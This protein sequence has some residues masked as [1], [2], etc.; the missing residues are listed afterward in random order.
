MLRVRKERCIGGELHR[1]LIA[2]ESAHE[3]RFADRRAERTVARRI[4]DDGIFADE[5]A[6]IALRRVVF[7]REVPHH[8]VGRRVEMIVA[9]IGL[10][11]VDDRFRLLP[12][13][14]DER[15]V[16]ILRR[17]GIRHQLV[18]L[19]VLLAAVLVADF[20]ILEVKGFRMS[21]RGALRAPDG[22]R[23]AVAV[24]ET[25]ERILNELVHLVHRDRLP[26]G[27]ADVDA[28]ERLRLQHLCEQQVFVETDTVGGPV[29]PDV[30]LRA[31]VPLVP[32]RFLPPVRL[33]HRIALDPAAARKTDE[34][35]IQRRELLDK[36][37]AKESRDRII[38]KERDTI[39][40]QFAA[41]LHPQD[42]SRL[43]IV[44]V[45]DE[46]HAKRPPVVRH[47]RDLGPGQHRLRIRLERHVDTIDAV[48]RAERHLEMIGH[49][50]ADAHTEIALVR[51]ARTGRSP[52]QRRMPVFL[53][54][55]L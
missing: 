27:H 37:L 40:V 31:P 51:D 34:A 8:P 32:E 43:R 10:G 54:D 19:L 21:R 14:E 30:P 45:G 29:L 44:V 42:E 15:H 13:V 26:V 36:V 17:H 12:V 55:R 50:L 53:R 47:P 16:G 2:L 25:V 11:A 5:D 3:R 41:V 18:A 38:R 22:V 52:H 20:E 46:R 33:L 24:F 35:R 6:E 7:V 49:P 23:V 39:D 4:A 9:E 1:L 28:E 48:R